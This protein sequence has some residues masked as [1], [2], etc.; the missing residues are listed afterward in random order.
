ME[1]TLGICLSVKRALQALTPDRNGQAMV[2]AC[3]VPPEG[4]TSDAFIRIRSDMRYVSPVR[5]VVDAACGGKLSEND[6]EDLKLAVGEAVCNAIEH[7]SPRAQKDYVCIACTVN[8]D[9]VTVSVSDSGGRFFER[10][11]KRR[12]EKLRERGY[13]LLLIQKLTSAVHIKSNGR[14]ATVTLEKRFSPTA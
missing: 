8:E 1:K 13:G 7:G 3:E 11:R 5:A 12:P 14:G 2:S 10:R 4:F 6:K 9:G